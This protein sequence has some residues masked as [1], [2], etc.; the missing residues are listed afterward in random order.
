MGTRLR[1]AATYV[2][3]HKGVALLKGYEAQSASRPVKAGLADL[4]ERGRV[5]IA[6][7]ALVSLAGI[8]KPEFLDPK[9]ISNVLR[10]SA[11]LGTVAIGQTIVMIAGEFDLSVSAIMQLV[12]VVV[13]EITGGRNELLLPAVAVCLLLGMLIGFV[14]GLIVSRRKGSSFMITL[15]MGLAVTGARL[16]Y[17]QA[18]P[19]GT[20]PANLRPLSQSDLLGVPFSLVLLLALTLF[21]WLVLRKTTFGRQLYAYGANSEAARLSGVRV[22]WIPVIAFTTSGFLAAL[23]GLVLAAYI[24]YI[25]QWLGGGYD[26]DSIAAAA[27][28][29]VSLAGG[30]GGVGGTLAGVLLIRMLMNFVLVVG[31]PI[32][33]QYVVRGAVVILAVALYSLRLPR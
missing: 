10:Q 9:N 31:L 13:A 15:A 26:L 8:I 6:V 25:D 11:A 1:A 2:G 3:E 30:K 5:F 29:G 22:E 4:V 16:V 7:V 33:Y 24:G 20:L 27:I 19:S 18:T 17:T 14:N 23:A 21:V 12:T 28:G 32:E